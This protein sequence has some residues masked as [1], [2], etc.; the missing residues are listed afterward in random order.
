[1][2]R[3]LYNF[4]VIPAMRGGLEILRP[5]HPKV[6]EGADG[7]KG[8]NRS[9]QVWRSENTGPLA[10]IHSASAGEF[11][12][13]IPIIE[14]LKK[15]KIKTAA[16]L[17]S[18][19]GYQLAIKNPL[20]EGVFYLPFDSRRMVRSFLQALSP[21][22][23]V[24][25]KHDIWPNT[26]WQCSDLGIPLII[27]NTNLH[28]KSSRLNPLLIRFN[29]DIFNRFETI[30]TV[31]ENHAKRIAL[32]AGSPERIS[33]VGDSRFDR[34]VSRLQSADV[35][36]PESFDNSPVLIGGSVW[37]AEDFVLES[38]TELHR[39]FPDWKLIWVPHEPAEEYMSA[40]EKKL[41]AAGLQTIRFTE[42]DNYRG[43]EALIVDKVGV[44]PPLYRYADVAYVGGGF[45]K[46]VHSVIEPAAF[47]IP[48]IFGPNNHVSAE[49]GELLRKK[50]GYSVNG[51]E[52]FLPLLKEM[53]GG[54]DLRAKTGRIAGQYVAEK[55]GAAEFIA[56]KI[57]DIISHR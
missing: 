47:S 5:F 53:M 1:M 31:S 36:L 37:P 18:P 11:E 35:K 9:A 16:T 4:L 22:V 3:F 13:A 49:A 23:F 27:A 21:D 38:Y 50:G 39:S 34:V 7:R 30:F 2:Y 14:E 43:E 29:R 42:L 8:L 12:A 57:A 33:S 48:V 40:S 20:P 17:Y 54:G 56:Q 45:G 46:G 51:K 10:V 28:R 44:L 55:T 26:V 52:E 32:I 19:S 6:R 15:R 25:C 24:F 41:E